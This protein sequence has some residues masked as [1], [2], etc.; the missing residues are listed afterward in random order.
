MLFTCMHIVQPHR[1]LIVRSLKAFA[2]SIRI[3]IAIS[4]HFNTMWSE[5]DTRAS[6]KTFHFFSLSPFHRESIVDFRKI[7]AIL[8]CQA[9]ES[10]SKQR[11]CTFNRIQWDFEFKCCCCCWK[12]NSNNK[13]NSFSLS[14]RCCD[15]IYLLSVQLVFLRVF[16]VVFFFALYWTDHMLHSLKCAIARKGHSFDKHLLLLNTRMSGFVD[17]KQQ[18]NE[19]LLLQYRISDCTAKEQSIKSPWIAFTMN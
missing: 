3:A 2:H 8:R 5:H 10:K 4:M 13:L 1:H 6:K 14:A 16:F 17:K 18:G 9:I 15:E 12:H 11:K 19:F 7:N